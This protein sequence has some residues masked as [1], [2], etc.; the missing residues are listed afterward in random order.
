MTAIAL[1]IL[2]I[3]QF[4]DGTARLSAAEVVLA[5]G[6]METEVVDTIAEIAARLLG[7]E[8][9]EEDDGEPDSNYWNLCQ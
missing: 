2:N 9:A 1:V 5:P 7:R 8:T 6:E 4:Q 3:C